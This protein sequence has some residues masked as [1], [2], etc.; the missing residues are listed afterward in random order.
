VET[1]IINI[2]WIISGL[3]IILY[4]AILLANVMSLRSRSDRGSMASVEYWRKALPFKTIQ[5][6]TTL[7]PVIDYACQRL[8][9]TAFESGTLFPAI[10]WMLPPL[11]T[12][13]SIFW[14]FKRSRSGIAV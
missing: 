1:I 9:R 5:V 8:S 14:I 12:T 7:F 13:V 3:G 10:M 6:L 2:V 11:L 4:P